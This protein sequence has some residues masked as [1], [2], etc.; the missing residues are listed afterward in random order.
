M[1]RAHGVLAPPDRQA[2]AETIGWRRGFAV[3]LRRAAQLLPTIVD[4]LLDR[5][6]EPKGLTGQPF[7]SSIFGLLPRCRPRVLS[8]PM[9]KHETPITLAFW[10]SVGG[11]LIEEYRVVEGLAEC[12]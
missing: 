9:S 8:T 12:G 7:D 5:Q 10:E 4:D 1:E 3:A 2:R 6:A 11:T